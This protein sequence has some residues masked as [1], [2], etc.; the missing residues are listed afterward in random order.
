[1][2]SRRCPERNN[3]EGPDGLYHCDRLQEIE[4]G[5]IGP[6]G[7]VP[8]NDGI[9]AGAAPP[10]ARKTAIAARTEAR[11][12]QFAPMRAS[13]WWAGKLPW[14]STIG[15]ARPYCLIMPRVAPGAVRAGPEGLAMQSSIGPS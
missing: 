1:M 5:K 14:H 12:C 13:C 8:E 11:R 2:Q 6:E 4:P 10:N 3:S 9:G 7:P 15:M